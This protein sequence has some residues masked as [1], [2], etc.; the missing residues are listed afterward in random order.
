MS[1]TKTNIDLNKKDELINRKLR[2]R[3]PLSIY[4]YLNLV[5]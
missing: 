3:V 5:R 1:D 4:Y 2:K